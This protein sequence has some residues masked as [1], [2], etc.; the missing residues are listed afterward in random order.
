MAGS[1]GDGQ[2]RGGLSF[3]REYEALQPAV[4]YYRGDKTKYPPRGVAGGSDGK[5]SRFLMHPDT[6]SE[7]QMPANCRVELQA[8]ERFRIE[9]AGGGG[10]GDPDK[11]STQARARDREDGYVDT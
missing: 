3:R 8:G 2:Y 6:E 1:G 11:R 10:F 9:G 7:K 5:M 4:V